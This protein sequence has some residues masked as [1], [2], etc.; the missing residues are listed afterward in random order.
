MPHSKNDRRPKDLQ[1][2]IDE[3]YKIKYEIHALERVKH[4][5]D[6]STPEDQEEDEVKLKEFLNLS[7]YCEIKLKMLKRSYDEL[8][9]CVIFA[10]DHQKH[11][12]KPI[13]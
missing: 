1:N 3:M 12:L 10:M 6:L 11:D 9:R 2:M 5:C 13:R 7:V 8:M 4:K